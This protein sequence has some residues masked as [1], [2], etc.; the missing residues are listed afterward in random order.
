MV[1]CKSPGASGNIR[2]K[3]LSR[4]HGMRQ[5]TFSPL[6]A[7]VR[8]LG[9]LLFLCA[10]PAQATVF[11]WV[12]VQGRMWFSNTPPSHAPQSS[13]LQPVACEPTLAHFVPA[14][15]PS[16]HMTVPLRQ[17]GEAFV[18]EALLN[19]R[20][21]YPLV[22][23][24]GADV[25]VIPAAVAHLLKLELHDAPAQLVHT[26][27]GHLT[28][29]RLV[30]TSLTVGRA[31]VRQVE[32]LIAE[33]GVGPSESGLLGLSFLRHFQLILNPAVPSLTLIPLVR[34]TP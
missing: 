6:L 10:I 34:P 9:L 25:T 23:D 1:V 4:G 13:P 22:L 14:M 33:H 32:V 24:T 8:I 7:L 29:R 15:M 27:G 31:T 3:V 18:M 16:D 30:L 28:A 26:A 2:G 19:E 17:H 20:L 21:R 11:R 12:D 5:C